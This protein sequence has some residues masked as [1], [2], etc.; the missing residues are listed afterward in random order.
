VGASALRAPVVASTGLF[1]RLFGSSSATMADKYPVP[2]SFPVTKTA[3]E[4]KQKLNKQEY[5]VLFKKDTERA[6]TGRFPDCD[7]ARAESYRVC[8]CVS[9][10]SLS[11]RCCA[12]GELSCVH[13]FLF[14]YVC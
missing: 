13:V 1:S 6:G 14:E 7:A 4:W 9:F 12:C 11:L 10:E 3:D 8:V 2:S 5:D